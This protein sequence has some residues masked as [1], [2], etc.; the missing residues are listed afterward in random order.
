V[1]ARAVA[2][3]VVT[4]L[5]AAWAGPLAAQDAAAGIGLDLEVEVYATALAFYSPPRDQ[6]R[7]LESFEPGLRRALIARLGDRFLPWSEGARGQGGR[8]RVSPIEAA[9]PDRYR[10][11][12]EYRHRTPYFEGPISAQAFLV[13]CDGLRCAILSRGGVGGEDSE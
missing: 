3:G 7:W 6:V 10:L 8:L 11:V 1:S 2:C 12:V 9:G 4:L 5:A 13:R